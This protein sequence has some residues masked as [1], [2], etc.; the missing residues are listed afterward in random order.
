MSTL[1]LVPSVALMD[2]WESQIEHHVLPGTLSIYRYHGQGRRLDP[3]S[4]LPYHVVFSTYATV[5]SDFSR[6]GGVLSK[7]Q[8]Y[9]LILDEAH[10]I[11]NWTTQQFGAVN[12]LVANIRWCMTGTPIQNTVDDLGSLIKQN[13]WPSKL[14]VLGRDLEE[15]LKSDKS[16]VFSFWRQSL[17]VLG[18]LLAERGIP[19]YRVDGM[20]KPERRREVLRVFRS[21]DSA[22]VLLM[23]LGTGS[24]G[25]NDLD[26]ASRLHFMEPQWNPA[27]ESQAVGRL[28]RL[29]QEKQVCIV[30]YVVKD[31]IEEEDPAPES[32]EEIKFPRYPVIKGEKE[33]NF[34]DDRTDWDGKYYMIIGTSTSAIPASSP[35]RSSTRSP[36][37]TQRSARASP[38]SPLTTATSAT[39]HT[40]APE[41]S[42]TP[43]SS[44]SH[45]PAPITHFLLPNV[46]HGVTDAALIALTQHCPKLAEVYLTG[47]KLHLHNIAENKEA[48]KP[49]REA[50]KARPD[51]II[52][53][54]SKS[55]E[56][57]YGDWEMV[58]HTDVYFKGRKCPD[59]KLPKKKRT[60]NPPNGGFGGY[61]RYAAKQYYRRELGKALATMR[62]W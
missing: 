20:L 52:Y 46:G 60:Y 49:L 48:M 21:P 17:D 18:R 10:V 11:R 43:A 23:T 25:L 57:H 9:R 47:A 22:R 44:A 53:M 3:S 4:P 24:V 8:W 5:A 38:A 27:V 6:G 42:P 36:P 34:R 56:K 28:L 13:E 26:V 14:L 16:I 58:T 32:V 40:T 45:N 1:V 37:S 30:R 35:I 29:G 15:H 50:S 39:K 7:F 54:V 55:E 19:F 61:D 62:R 41:E 2:M 59:G 31:S 51:L 12:D 33:A